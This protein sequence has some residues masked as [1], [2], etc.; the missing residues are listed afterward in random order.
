MPNPGIGYHEPSDSVEYDRA[1]L[2]HDVLTG[3]H[4]S[5]LYFPD[6]PSL[7]SSWV[8]L[9]RGG[10]ANTGPSNRFGGRGQRGQ[11]GRGRGGGGRGGGG[12]PGTPA[13]RSREGG[14]GRGDEGRGAARGGEEPIQTVFQAADGRG[15]GTPT[16]GPSTIVQ[17]GRGGAATGTGRG[18][19]AVAGGG[20]TPGMNSVPN[21]EGGGNGGS[22]PRGRGRKGKKPSRGRGKNPGP[23]VN[24]DDSEEE[25]GPGEYAEF[26]A[27]FGWD[28][29]NMTIFDSD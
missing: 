15:R 21:G 22:R 5:T 23:R 13:G 28:V 2:A 1:T 6:D 7:A 9:Q 17:R 27:E 19:N 20:T 3:D 16:G 24:R 18:G 10:H 8:A 25:W 11:R 26:M 4:G 29:E 12:G 14:R